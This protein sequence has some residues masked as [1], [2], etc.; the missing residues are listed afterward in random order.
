MKI[1]PAASSALLSEMMEK[2]V[3]ISDF[4]TLI[5]FLQKNYSFL[6]PTKNNVTIKPYVYDRRI[7]WDTH[8]ICVS[9]KATF[10]SDGSFDSD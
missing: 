1:R 7:G 10:F 8:I 9:D 3:E 4:D 5:V 2:V 6:N